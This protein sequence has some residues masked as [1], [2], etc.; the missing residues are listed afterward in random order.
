MNILVVFTFGYSLKLWS[1]SKILERELSIYRELNNKYGLN[2]TFLTYGDRFDKDFLKEES[3]IEVIPI[4]EYFK[5][6]KS[7][8]VAY[9]QTFL[10]PFKFKNRLKKISI[11]KQHQILGVWV[12]VLLKLLVKCP[13]YVRTGYD[14]HLFAKYE[15]KSK[16]IQFLYFIINQLGIAFSNIYTVSNSFD[17]DNTKNKYFYSSNIEIRTNWI[18]ENKLMPFQSRHK[19]KVICVGRLEKQKNYFEIIENFK[20]SNYQIHIYGEGSLN[21]QIKSLSEKFN[22]DL[23]LMGTVDN[24]ELSNKLSEYKYFITS[25]FFEGNPK[26][27]MEAMGAG[28]VVIA[29]NIVNHR[30]LINNKENGILY[31]I[32]S[33]EL[34]K[35][36]IEIDNN[37]DEAEKISKK[38]Y[39]TSLSRFNLP[40]VAKKEY[41]DYLFII[42]P[43]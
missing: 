39:E 29:S 35:T 5:K 10:I 25:S 41:E 17:Y 11:I 34:I 9:F 7:K 43:V 8:L 30:D 4:Y 40:I 13:L 3:W 38:A 37:P 33:D 27:V 36:I 6:P 42:K 18:F 26:S 15:N 31:N 22:T 24:Y 12:S 19:D 21:K 14:M 16:L 28:C 20:D 32:G 1:D 23:L 2:F